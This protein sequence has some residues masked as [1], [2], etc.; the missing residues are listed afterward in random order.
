MLLNV[1]VR[2]KKRHFWQLFFPESRGKLISVTLILILEIGLLVYLLD[3]PPRVSAGFLVKTVGRHYIIA[4]HEPFNG[5]YRRS[6]EELSEATEFAQNS[7]GL[8]IGKNPELDLMPEYL[9]VKER[10]SQYILQWKTFQ[11]DFLNQ[12][13]FEKR[14]DALFFA[15]AFRGGSYSPSPFGHSVLFLP[16]SRP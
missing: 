13:T 16:K 5:L 9:T 10:L 4:W 14:Q 1:D 11:L 8:S 7:L 6:F 3:K 15:N 2:S 12:I